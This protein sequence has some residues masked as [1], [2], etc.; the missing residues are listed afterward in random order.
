MAIVEGQWIDVCCPG[1]GNTRTISHRQAR[2]IAHKQAS[3]ICRSCRYPAKRGRSSVA[4]RVF[5]VERFT[6][7]E[8]REMAEAIWGPQAVTASSKRRNSAIVRR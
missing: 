4:E 8:I 1:C 3:A 7:P 6:L 5:W 2:R